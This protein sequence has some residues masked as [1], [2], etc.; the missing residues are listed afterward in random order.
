MFCSQCGKKVMEN[1]L[2]CPFCGSPI[3]IPDQD[4]IEFVVPQKPANAENVSVSAPVA[5]RSAETVVRSEDSEDIFSVEAAPETV[6]APEKIRDERQEPQENIRTETIMIRQADPSEFKPLDLEAIAGSEPIEEQPVPE[7]SGKKVETEISE[8]LS[9]QLKQE[10]VKLEGHVP[11]LTNVKKPKTAQKKRRSTY[12]PVREFNPN[13]I[14]LDGGDKDYDDYDDEDDAYEYEDREEGGFF[15]RHI[16]G[17]GGIMGQLIDGSQHNSAVLSILVQAVGQL[18]GGQTCHIADVIE[19]RQAALQQILRKG[20]G[21][22]GIHH[23]RL[24]GVIAVIHADLVPGFND[25]LL[26]GLLAAQIAA[27]GIIF[28]LRCHSQHRQGKQKH[29]HR[30]DRQNTYTV[31]HGHNRIS[32]LY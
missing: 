2:F 15:V 11:D 7:E 23:R 29:Q 19:V 31:F 10:P 27:G 17:L 5:E 16:R 22:I 1:M 8:L 25:L 30:K 12:A 18:H 4:E 20:S 14:F 21:G 3:V 24:F 9:E 13:D 26:G 32:F 6:S 28:L